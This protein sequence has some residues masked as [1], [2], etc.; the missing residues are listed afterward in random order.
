[1][2]GGIA[3]EIPHLPQEKLHSL[4]LGIIQL[5]DEGNIVFYSKGESKLSGYAAEEVLG[6]HF[7]TDVAPC[8]NNRLIYRPFQEGILKGVLNMEVSYTFTYV[9]RPTN[10]RLH[11]FRHQDS[12]TNW[13][14]VWHELAM[15]EE[16]APES[17]DSE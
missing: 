4:P 14:L 1:M 6:R 2:Q 15:E 16:S 10:V 5:D 12:K 11:L 3:E 7:F 17:A 9:M 13:L 8:T